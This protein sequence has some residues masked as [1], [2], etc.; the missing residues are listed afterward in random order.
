MQREA[1][2]LRLVGHAA[3]IQHVLYSIH[4]YVPHVHAEW[5]ASPRRMVLGYPSMSHTPV[6]VGRSNGAS[7]SRAHFCPPDHIYVSLSPHRF[8]ASP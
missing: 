1:S 3:P 2:R 4:A 8:H 7:L 6:H 5:D